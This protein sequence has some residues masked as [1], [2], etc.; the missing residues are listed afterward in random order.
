MKQIMIDINDS[1]IKRNWLL[2]IKDGVIFNNYNLSIEHILSIVNQYHRLSC[3]EDNQ[4]EDIVYSIDNGYI[5]KEKV[6]NI[7][8]QEVHE[9]RLKYI[10]TLRWGDIIT[11]NVYV[12]KDDFE[13]KVIT[14]VV[15]DSILYKYGLKKT[16]V[17]SIIG[18]WRNE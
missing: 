2:T 12:C 16:D 6:N 5:V 10:L 14:E 17:R 9:Y 13:N 11:G 7:P 4:T 15:F 8:E 3:I 18:E 1:L